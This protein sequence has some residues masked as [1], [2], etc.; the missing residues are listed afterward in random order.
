MV[1]FRCCTKCSESKSVLEFPKHRRMLGG[2]GPRCKVCKSED[3]RLYRACNKDRLAKR[4]A[5]SYQEDKSKQRLRSQRYYEANKEL[6]KA[7]SKKWREENPE[8]FKKTRDACHKKKPWIK[9][10]AA[11]FRKLRIKRATPAWANLGAIKEFYKNKPDGHHV[12]HIIPLQ[13]KDVCGL[14]V[15]ENLQYLT[16]EENLRK[17][18][19]IL[20]TLS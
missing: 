6:V 12:D 18:N 15:L 16:A 9:R 11:T 10:S 14:H 1:E 13:G 5:N 8:Q 17:G 4:K 20:T 2:V 7:R 19:R 3:D